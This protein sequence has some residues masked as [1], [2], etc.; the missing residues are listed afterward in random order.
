[1]ILRAIKNGVSEERIAAALNVHVSSV[2]QKRDLLDGICD[3]AA[4]LL[5]NRFVTVSTFRIL[6]RMKPYRQI[7]AVELMTA[8]HNFG[9]PLATSI[10]AGTRAEDLVGSSRHKC[11]NRLNKNEVAQMQQVMGSLQQDLAA[12]KDHCGNDALTLSVSLKFISKL[13]TY[14]E[15]RKYLSKNHRDIVEE[16]E[17]LTRQHDQEQGSDAGRDGR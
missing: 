7:E 10:L 13:L 5:K 14:E 17:V 12:I 2:R 1:M 3:E 16:L 6:K 11:V 8:A 9:K 4:E 15:I